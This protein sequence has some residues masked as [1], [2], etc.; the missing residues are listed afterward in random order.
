MET[1]LQGGFKVLSVFEDHSG[2]G[3]ARW[4]YA[5]HKDGRT[6]VSNSNRNRPMGDDNL[7][8]PR[9]FLPDQHDL[10]RDVFLAKCRQYCIPC[11]KVW[12]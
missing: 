5:L 8:H 3:V 4:I 11:F 10:A 2:M 1:R 7:H 6:L 9:I 12:D